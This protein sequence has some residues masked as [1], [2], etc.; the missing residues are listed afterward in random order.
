MSSVMAVCLVAFH[1]FVHISLQ[2]CELQTRPC[3]CGSPTLGGGSLTLRTVYSSTHGKLLGGDPVPL[4]TQFRESHDCA[5][6]ES[7]PFTMTTFSA[8]LTNLTVL[9]SHTTAAAT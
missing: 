8:S 9:L 1:F 6:L 5:L 7:W 2:I 4:C 3:R